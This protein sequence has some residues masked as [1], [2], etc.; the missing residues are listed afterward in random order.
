MKMLSR[1]NV[2]LT[3]GVRPMLDLL[4]HYAVNITMNRTCMQQET[5]GII[6]TGRIQT[7]LIVSHMTHCNCKYWLQMS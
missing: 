5:V 1:N 4:N 2:E 3:L 7:F 6:V